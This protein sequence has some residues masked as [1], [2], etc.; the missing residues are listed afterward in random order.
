MATKKKTTKKTA[1][2][3]TVKPMPKQ[4]S[5]K[6]PDK[7][8]AIIGLLI[9]VLIFPGLGTII[10]GKTKTGIIQLVLMVVSIP[11]MLVLIG[12]LLAF[13]I[14]IWGIVSGVQLIQEAQ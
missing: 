1:V 10:G 14:W 11:L 6:K 9:N 12:F 2:K 7:T 4:M 3:E 5:G 8:L 13:G